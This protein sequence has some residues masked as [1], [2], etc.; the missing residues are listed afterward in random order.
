[1]S[2]PEPEAPQSGEHEDMHDPENYGGLSVEDDPDG[3]VDPKKAQEKADDQ[4]Q[5]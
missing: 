2:N 5:S 1:M 3:E 4:Q